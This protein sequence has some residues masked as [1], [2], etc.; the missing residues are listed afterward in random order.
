MKVAFG[1]VIMMKVIMINE[2]VGISSERS[3]T[4][5]T[6]WIILELNVCGLETMLDIDGRC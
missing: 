3:E 4:L 6:S 5:V 1:M 2:G